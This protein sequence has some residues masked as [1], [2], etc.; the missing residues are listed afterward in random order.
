MKN[1][2]FRKRLVGLSL[3]APLAALANAVIYGIILLV[4]FTGAALFITY[5]YHVAFPANDPNVQQYGPAGVETTVETNDIVEYYEAAGLAIALYGPIMNVVPEPAPDDTTATDTAS[6]L[7]ALSVT[8]NYFSFHFQVCELPLTNGTYLSQ[9][10][11]V[12][13]NLTNF[14]NNVFNY[15]SWNS[16]NSN[17][18][19]FTF[20]YG[21]YIMTYFSTNLYTGGSTGDILVTDTVHTVVILRSTNF[22]TWTPLKTNQTS[23]NVDNVFTD[24]NCPAGNSV[25]YRTVTY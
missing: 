14:L 3:L 4:T 15:N 9:P 23:G 17:A 19:A 21:Q 11:W 18:V 8:N 10:L 13:N 25:F 7:L 6:A 24:T 12:T 20:G 1:S 2:S 22:L 16:G 5:I